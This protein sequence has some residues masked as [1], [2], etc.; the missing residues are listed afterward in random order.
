MLACSAGILDR[1]VLQFLF[2]GALR[3]ALL[4][5]RLERSLANDLQL[6][7]LSTAAIIGGVA[8]AVGLECPLIRTVRVCIG[9]ARPPAR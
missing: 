1:H 3:Q 6:L 5:T 8:I 2:V 7:M 9:T 4:V